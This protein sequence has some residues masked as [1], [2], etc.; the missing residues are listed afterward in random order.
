MRATAIQ[1]AINKAN[2]LAG[3][4]A[5]MSLK[6]ISAEVGVA[7]SRVCCLAN[8]LGYRRMYV[9]QSERA[10]LLTQRAREDAESAKSN[11]AA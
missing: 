3:I 5:D 11:Q 4:R 8:V 10:L 9:N 6:A 7:V 1:A 2:I